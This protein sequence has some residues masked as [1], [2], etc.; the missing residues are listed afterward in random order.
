MT[1]LELKIS[2]FLCFRPDVEGLGEFMP[3]AVASSCLGAGR[4][5]QPALGVIGTMYSPRRT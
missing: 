2:R 4:E 1:M 3:R 5:N